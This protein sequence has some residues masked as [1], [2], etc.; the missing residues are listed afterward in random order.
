MRSS[1]T[2]A[3]TTA[4]GVGAAYA[5]S[6]GQ[7][8]KPEAAPGK[9][10]QRRD[11]KETLRGLYNYAAELLLGAAYD[12]GS[13][14]L[15]R[16]MDLKQQ[17]IRLGTVIEAEDGDVDAAVERSVRHARKVARN[18]PA[19][20]TNLLKIQYE[21]SLKGLSESAA[22][23][24][25]EVVAKLAKVTRGEDK[26]IS[27]IVG[28]V[29]SDMNQAVEAHWY[30]MRAGRRRAVTV[31]GGEGEAAYVLRDNYSDERTAREAARAKLAALNRAAGDLRLTL[32]PG[33][34]R[35]RAE[36]PLTLTDFPAGLN[37]SRTVIQ[38]VH[39]L[40]EAGYATRVEAQAFD[41][42]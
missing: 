38:A 25:S 8:G 4:G 39:E 6:K 19:S 28:S 34:P 26:N 10:Q 9:T 32:A 36:T 23:A 31:S 7:L 5:A 22:R 29:F 16:A 14:F 15:G 12:A 35:V 3:S 13:M 18:S 27:K 41:P 33:N 30:D 42:R 20:E 11:N 24:G 40:N 1:L 37:G 2:P 21:L 17:R